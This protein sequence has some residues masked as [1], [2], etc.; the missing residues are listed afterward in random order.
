MNAAIKPSES[1]EKDANRQEYEI[2]R[3]A[4]I[5]WVLD[6]KTSAESLEIL[7]DI[8]TLR[9]SFLV[10]RALK[11]L[12]I[13]VDRALDILRNYND[14]TTQRERE[15]RDI[16][17]AAVDN[18]VDFAVAQE[19]AMIHELP[20]DLNNED[21]EE[22]ETVCERYNLTYAAEENSTVLFAAMIANWWLSIDANTIIT[23]MTQADERVRPWHEALE[24]LSYR[25]Q[26]FPPELV[27]PIEW[28]CRCFLVADGFGS[29]YG[30]ASSRPKHH[31][32][33]VNPVF[34]ESLATRGRIFTDAHP[35]FRHKLSDKLLNIGK[36]IK[37]KFGL[38]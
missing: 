38:P 2:I 24:G 28:G 5:R 13:D 8:I 25:K 20:E 21:I 15:Q 23:F 3:T 29:V 6:A 14:F 27:P 17:I 35:Y 1:P 9:A 34:S 31:Q 11:G 37:Q 4:F 26:E 19:F 32:P 30:A 18:L 36:H 10:D 12:R 16:L 7:E 33:Q 22:Y